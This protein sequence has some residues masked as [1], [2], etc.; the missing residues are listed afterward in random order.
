ML[1]IGPVYL[2]SR[3]VRFWKHR[4]TAIFRSVKNRVQI[5]FPF[6][7]PEVD[8]L[9]ASKA[10]FT[11]RV[12]CPPFSLAL[13]QIVP[14]NQD[15]SAS[16]SNIVKVKIHKLCLN[17]FIL[18]HYYQSANYWADRNDL[19]LSVGDIVLV[20]KLDTPLHFNTVLRV[21]KNVF[22]TGKLV[23]PISGLKCLGPN[24]SLDVLESWLGSSQEP[25]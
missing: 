19:E 13:G 16:N 11:G 6:H 8:G 15:V 7:K 1:K 21:K 4:G 20:E 14:F 5:Y 25:K 17:R 24:Y 10:E 2:T 23:D 18:K 12:P 3:M 9:T 22:P